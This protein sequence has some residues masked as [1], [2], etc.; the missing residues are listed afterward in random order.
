MDSNNNEK[1]RHQGFEDRVTY[2]KGD[3]VFSNDTSKKSLTREEAM[4]ELIRRRDELLNSISSSYYP[5]QDG[6]S[7]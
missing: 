7:R 2:H 3:G 5:R 4:Q 1:N 6:K